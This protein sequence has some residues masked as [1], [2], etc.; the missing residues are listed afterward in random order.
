MPYSWFYLQGPNL[1]KFC[2]RCSYNMSSQILFPQLCLYLYFNSVIITH[3]TILCLVVLLTQLC[4]YKNFKIIAILILFYCSAGPE[5]SFL[6]YIFY[7]K[8]STT[9]LQCSST[10]HPCECSRTAY[11]IGFC[12]RC[13]LQHLQ[14]LMI[15]KKIT[16]SILIIKGF[17]IQLII[18]HNQCWAEKLMLPRN[19][20]L[21]TIAAMY[22]AYLHLPK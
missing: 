11:C 21:D 4:L 17:H 20:T 5:R 3:V 14:N 19:Q 1:G 6:L 7:H 15:L 16:W 10:K 13:Q 18:A 8:D 2:A 9:L 22:G 12:F